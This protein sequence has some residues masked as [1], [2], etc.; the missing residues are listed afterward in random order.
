L[1]T[2]A[3]ILFLAVTLSFQNNSSNENGFVVEKTV[4]GNCTDG[5]SVFTYLPVNAT[6]ITDSL[7][8]AGDCY[9]VAAYNE[10]GV[11]EYSNVVKVPMTQTPCETKQNECR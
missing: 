5:F 3:I 2:L 11:S 9:R 7:G 10:D 1:N 8:A 6:S 4:S